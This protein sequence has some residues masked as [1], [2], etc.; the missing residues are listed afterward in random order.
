ML[1]QNKDLTL[2][3]IAINMVANRKTGHME[4]SKGMQKEAG[5]M[6][7]EKAYVKTT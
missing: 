6:I 1:H 5:K 2:E 7:K 4:M 3:G